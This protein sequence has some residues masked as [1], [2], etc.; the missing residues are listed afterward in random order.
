MRPASAL[1]SP[2]APDGLGRGGLGRV[3]RPRPPSGLPGPGQR[4]LSPSARAPGVPCQRHRWACP[5]LGLPRGRVVSGVMGP[6]A[7]V[8]G[9]SGP[10]WRLG[11]GR[12]PRGT[13]PWPSR[14]WV[15]PGRAWVT[16]SPRPVVHGPREGAPRSARS[17]LPGRPC[18]IGLL[19]GGGR[20]V[21]GAPGLRHPP[22]RGHARPRRCPE[23]RMAEPLPR[24]GRDTGERRPQPSPAFLCHLGPPGPSPAEPA[25]PRPPP[26]GA[27]GRG[28]GP[29]R[30]R[31]WGGRGEL[32]LSSS[33]A[34]KA[35][36]FSGGGQRPGRPAGRSRGPAVRR[37]P[38][39]SRCAR[40]GCHQ[41]REVPPAVRS[42]RGTGAAPRAQPSRREAPGAH[43]PRSC[44]ESGRSAP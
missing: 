32:R 42:G 27:R 35:A 8:L 44:G 22:S 13:G 4:R 5:G 28:R 36:S 39:Q 9:S 19:V 37:R 30:G 20:P 17:P 23:K 10:C 21:A 16:G 15:T 1:S 38:G 34:F 14:A 31:L 11:V 7:R 33:P 25:A 2:P 43:R 26:S 12:Q 41:H 3:P 40:V 18:A 24:T 6:R 29:P